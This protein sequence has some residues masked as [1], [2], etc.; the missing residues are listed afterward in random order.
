VFVSALWS[1]V[2]ALLAARL[3]RNLRAGAVVGFLVF[4]HWLLDFL[5]WPPNAEL[6]KPGGY[7]TA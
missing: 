5:M 2:A 7:I 4:S 6:L 1:A 3:Y